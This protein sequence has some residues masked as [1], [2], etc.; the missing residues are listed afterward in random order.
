MECL[1]GLKAE[2][3]GTEIGLADVGRADKVFA[4]HA[5]GQY[6]GAQKPS[7][8]DGDRFEVLSG[9]HGREAALHFHRGQA[10]LL[11]ESLQF[12]HHRERLLQRVTQR[13][14]QLEHRV[15]LELDQVGTDAKMTDRQPVS[16]GVV[17]L[18]HLQLGCFI[19][20][21]FCF[22]SGEFKP[23]RRLLQNLGG[24]C[25]SGHDRHRENQ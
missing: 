16:T 6:L 21:Y 11:V 22:H 19:S 1:V 2:H 25:G 8:S 17:H 9:I 14:K 4:L 18:E 24:K 7:G 3:K 12:L 13:N 15:E 20:S 23:L 10:R 5:E